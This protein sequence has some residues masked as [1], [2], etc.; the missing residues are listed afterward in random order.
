MNPLALVKK[1]N[2]LGHSYLTMLLH[3]VV[4]DTREEKEEVKSKK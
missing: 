1:S 4:L 3:H 2:L